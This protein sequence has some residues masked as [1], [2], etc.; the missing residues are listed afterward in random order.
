MAVKLENTDG[1][2][3]QDKIATIVE[4]MTTELR[5]EAIQKASHAYSKAMIQD[6]AMY[7]IMAEEQER[8]G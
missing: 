3:G 7:N 2:Q 8:G 6:R 4:E 5:Q 1:L